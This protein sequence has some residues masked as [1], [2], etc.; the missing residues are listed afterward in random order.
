MMNWNCRPPAKWFRTQKIKKQQKSRLQ[1]QKRGRGSHWSSHTLRWLTAANTNPKGHAWYLLAS[2]SFKNYVLTYSFI[3]IPYV[4]SLRARTILLFH[5]IP[6]TVVMHFCFCLCVRAWTFVCVRAHNATV[7]VWRLETALG[8]RSYIPS[9]WF[10]GLNSVCRAWQQALLAS[11]PSPWSPL[12][13]HFFL[14]WV[15]LI[16]FNWI[17]PTPFCEWAVTSDAIEDMKNILIPTQ[18]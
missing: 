5:Y 15:G 3:S 11:E 16:H 18:T 1:W 4:S 17:K 7:Y 6:Y 9:C 13:L 8:V 14:I 10:W 12:V 2:A